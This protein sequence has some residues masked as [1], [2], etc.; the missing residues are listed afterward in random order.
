VTDVDD[1]LRERASQRLGKVL[2]GK[3]RLDSVLGIG[4]M[5]TVYRATHRNQAEFAIKVLH[6]ELSMSAAVKTRFIREGYAANMVKH[7]GVVRVV[8]DDIDEDGQAFLVMDLLEGRGLDHLHERARGRL[9]PALACGLIVQLLDVL[10]AAHA[11]NVIHRDIKPANLFVTHDGYLK[12]LDF[13]IARARAEAMSSATG[14]GVLLGTPAFMSP[15]QASGQSEAVDARSDLWS[16]GATLFTLLTG[17]HVHDAEGAMQLVIAAATREARSLT[18]LLPALDP[19]I[20]AVVARSLALA[21]ADRWSSAREMREALGA[22]TIAAFG[23]VPT[24]AML[25]SWIEEEGPT[26]ASGLHAIHDALAADAG[27]SAPLPDP[28]VRILSSPS[29]ASPSVPFRKT[30]PPPAENTAPRSAPLG[31]TTTARPVSSS[32]EDASLAPATKSPSRGWRVGV[33]LVALLACGA[34]V[35][36]LRPPTTSSSRASAAPL[37]PLE[38]QVATAATEAPRPSVEEPAPSPAPTAAA[39]AERPTKPIAMPRAA[40]SAPAPRPRPVV[41]AASAPPVAPP[42]PP[43]G[44]SCTPNY[45]LDA[46]GVKHWKPECF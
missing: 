13:G 34:L 3:Y 18:S 1:E 15:E 41:A 40:T 27:V 16:A 10:A 39:P 38:P 43:P 14:A 11:S 12:V 23:T 37:P 21:Q 22:A 29:L 45:T 46:D 9:P 36:A 25:S 30:E 19:R 28:R 35:V 6:P 2:R 24:P 33:P 17:E 42:P 7:P 20:V 32:P 26:Q 44:K 8:D 31:A 5:A 4:G